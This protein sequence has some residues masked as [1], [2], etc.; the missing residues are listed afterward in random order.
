MDNLLYLASVH[1]NNVSD[2][3][4]S[5]LSDGNNTSTE[6]ALPPRVLVFTTLN[7]LGLL[8]VS[9]KASVDGTFKVTLHFL[10]VPKQN[11]RLNFDQAYLL[12][13]LVSGGKIQAIEK[14]GLELYCY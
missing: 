6:L 14:M 3:D 13:V 5:I 2:D 1:E 10:S 12:I 11:C 7:L 4:G 9:R 8:A